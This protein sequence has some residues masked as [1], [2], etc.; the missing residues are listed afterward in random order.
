[1]AQITYTLAM[2]I[3]KLSIALLQLRIIGQA[4]VTMRRITLAS[5]AVNVIIG[6]YE[7]F[8]L[9]F[10]CTPVRHASTINVVQLTFCEAQEVLDADHDD[11]SL[12]GQKRR[13][14]RRVRIFSH[15]PGAG[16]VLR[17]RI[18]T[19]GLEAPDENNSQDLD[20][21]GFRHGSLVCLAFSPQRNPAKLS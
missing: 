12:R 6:L 14:D 11:G 5:I 13:R 20:Y 1:M 15:Q 18:S 21:I 4:S 3:T 10:Q 9:L 7:F 19:Y 2:I 16:L 8:A 17:P